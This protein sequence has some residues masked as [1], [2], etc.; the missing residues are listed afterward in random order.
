[1]QFVFV[2]TTTQ[3]VDG[4]SDGRWCIVGSAA[5]DMMKRKQLDTIQEA[6]HAWQTHRT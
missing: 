2:F 5:E 3:G 1:M 6:P 4:D